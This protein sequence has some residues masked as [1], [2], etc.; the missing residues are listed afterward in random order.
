[1]WSDSCARPE[2][3]LEQLGRVE[4]EDAVDTRHKALCLVSMSQAK[5]RAMS[6]NSY[7][8]KVGRGADLMNQFKTIIKS[9]GLGD[10]A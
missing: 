6:T 4:L 5:K 9:K 2:P 10:A 3:R 1:M 7:K 8:E